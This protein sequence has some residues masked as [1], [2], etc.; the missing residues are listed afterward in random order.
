MAL[1]RDLGQWHKDRPATWSTQSIDHQWALNQKSTV[2]DEKLEENYHCHASCTDLECCRRR[3]LYQSGQLDRVYRKAEQL[4]RRKSND[5]V[6]RLHTLHVRQQVE[7]G[8]FPSGIRIALT[9]PG[10]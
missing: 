10:L 6:H 5:A 3:D 8:H 7:G 1:A 9:A 4:I 2:G